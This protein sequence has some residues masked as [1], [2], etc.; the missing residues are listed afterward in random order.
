MLR[1]HQ[2]HIFPM[3]WW[4]SHIIMR[5]EMIFILWIWGK[6]KSYLSNSEPAEHLLW[7]ANKCY[8]S[9]DIQRPLQNKLPS[10]YEDF[11]SYRLLICLVFFFF[12]AFSVQDTA[13][14]N[15]HF[16]FIKQHEVCYQTK[17]CHSKVVPT[18]K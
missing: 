16:T 11:L 15:F 8:I 6:K 10:Q 17:L 18:V 4:G 2:N 1:G 9:Y 5:N 12:K 7:S 14:L 3:L 13:A